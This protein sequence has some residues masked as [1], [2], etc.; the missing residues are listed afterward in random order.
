MEKGTED[1]MRGMRKRKGEMVRGKMKGMNQ[2]KLD[3]GRKGK[4]KGLRVVRKWRE[5]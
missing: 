2:G 3:K 1:R 5:H 4:G